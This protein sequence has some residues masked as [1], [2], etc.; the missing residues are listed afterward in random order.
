MIA[1]TIQTVG[2]VIDNLDVLQL[3]IASNN[4]KNVGAWTSNSFHILSH[5]K[6]RRPA[7]VL[8]QRMELTFLDPRAFSSL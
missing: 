4:P 3:I 1:T 6:E 7:F 5:E 2:F 8:L